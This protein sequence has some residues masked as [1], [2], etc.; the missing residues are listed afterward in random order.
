MQTCATAAFEDL[1]EKRIRS[2]LVSIL[3]GLLFLLVIL[4]LLLVGFFI[5]FLLVIALGFCVGLT[6]V[7]RHEEHLLSARL[8][9][10]ASV[11][12][13]MKKYTEKI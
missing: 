5:V 10:V 7:L 12:Q 4:L 2:A 9:T 3:I 6:V 13:G 1:G 8:S 11:A